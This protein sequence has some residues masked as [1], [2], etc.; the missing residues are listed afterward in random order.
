[1]NDSSNT[2][3][4]KGINM[5]LIQL[6]FCSEKLGD[7]ICQHSDANIEVSEGPF[8]QASAFT[9]S[10]WHKSCGQEEEGAHRRKAATSALQ[11]RL[12]R[13]PLLLFH[14]YKWSNQ[15]A[16]RNETQAV[17]VLHQSAFFH[18]QSC[19]SRIPWNPNSP[20]TLLGQFP[21]GVCPSLCPINVCK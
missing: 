1:M 19:P 12:E 11:G 2:K 3:T 7:G 6:I 8:H 14:F 4:K 10:W 21:G 17:S 9:Q 15:A 13:I 16:R 5:T 18:R 20:T